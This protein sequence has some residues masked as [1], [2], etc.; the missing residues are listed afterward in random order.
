MRRCTVL[1]VCGAVGFQS[2][3]K[4][5]ERLSHWRLWNT[6]RYGQWSDEGD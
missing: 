6:P 4:R 3:L 1:N 2:V 5:I